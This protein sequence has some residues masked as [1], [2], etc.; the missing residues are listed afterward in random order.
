MTESRSGLRVTG[1]AADQL[2]GGDGGATHSRQVV[3]IGLRD[4]LDQARRAQPPELARH[5]RRRQ[6]ESSH[7]IGSTPPAPVLNA[8]IAR[9]RNR[10]AQSQPLKPAA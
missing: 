7:E 4:L 5:G 9:M 10:W 8:I 6:F 3:A 2:R 1:P